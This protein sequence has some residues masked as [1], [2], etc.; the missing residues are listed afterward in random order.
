MA[1]YKAGRCTPRTSGHTRIRQFI[2]R[3]LAKPFECGQIEP[4]SGMNS[5]FTVLLYYKYVPISDPETFVA[6]HLRLCRE[7]GLNGRVL[8]AEEGINGTLAGTSEATNEYQAWCRNHPLFADMAFKINEADEMPFKRLSVKARK[9]IVTLGVDE[10][11]D[12]ES[13][14]DNHLSAEEWKRT[15]EEEDVV[16]FDVRNDY[17]SAVGRFKGAITPAI[18]NFRELPKALKDYAHLKDKKVLMYCTGGIRCEKASALFR[19]EGFKEVYQLDGGILTYGEKLGPAHWEG[20]CFVFDERMMVPVGGAEAAPPIAACAHT[21]SVG[22]V[23][24]NCRDDLCHR[25]FPVS[26]VALEE[27]PN[28]RLCPDCVKKSMKDEL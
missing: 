1:S 25:L 28:Y 14:P 13:E 10:G 21:G 5:A 19:R 8:V 7:L 3:K 12:L 15:I 4:F 18:G 27:N 26:E 17:E 11:F 2:H 16:L 24:I 23:L 6:E 22:A 20:E 9:E